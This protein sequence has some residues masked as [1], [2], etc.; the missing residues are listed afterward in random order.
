MILSKAG[1]RNVSPEKKLALICG[2][3][4][5]PMPESVLLDIAASDP[6]ERVRLT[7]AHK[8]CSMGST[9]PFIN[10]RLLALENTNGE[11]A[12]RLPD[13]IDAGSSSWASE[14]LGDDDLAAMARDKLLNDEERFAAAD[15][16]SSRNLREELLLEILESPQ[17][18]RKR[19]EAHR[20]FYAVRNVADNVI[21][22]RLYEKMARDDAYNLIW[23]LK[24][25]QEAESLGGTSFSREICDEI[26][27]SNNRFDREI[28]CK[29]IHNGHHWR[30]NGIV[31][32]T[33]ALPSGKLKDVQKE[34]FICIFCGE[35]K[36]EEA[37][38]DNDPDYFFRHG[39]PKLPDDVGYAKTWVDKVPGNTMLAGLLQYESDPVIIRYA[40]SK[41]P[42]LETLFIIACTSNNAETRKEAAVALYEK[43]KTNIEKVK[44]EES[45]YALSNYV[46]DE[47]DM[48]RLVDA[49]GNQ[50][51]LYE[52]GS[53]TQLDWR[54]RLAALKKVSDQ[55]K[56]GTL[57]IGEYSFRDASEEDLFYAALLN[58]ISDR[59]TLAAIWMNPGANLHCRWLA[60]AKIANP[61]LFFTSLALQGAAYLDAAVEAL[62]DDPVLL[63]KLAI[64]WCEDEFRLWGTR[65]TMELLLGKL[66]QE[67]Y[68]AAK[69]RRKLASMP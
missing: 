27:K 60:R 33:G 31:P 45:L 50:Q 11:Q 38:P 49:I 20:R 16:V 39:I 56:L 5:D 40:L 24:A 29:T 10:A 9:A 32:F 63:E 67:G 47:T 28:A 4:Y 44:D 66:D 21:R 62:A 19:F 30:Y 25:S 34:E 12:V 35:V 15:R 1:W 64:R 13:A 42:D 61:S 68:P 7:A 43:D 55:G 51:Y 52:I 18:D 3:R 36:P 26:F 23:Q 6:D 17:P 48:L 46:T 2:P 57:F 54:I 37:N 8:L 14:P 59:C 69:L 53:R 22:R 41:V 65:P 58:L